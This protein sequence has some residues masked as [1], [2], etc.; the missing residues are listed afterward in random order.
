MTSRRCCNDAR[1]DVKLV[2][3]G[4]DIGQQQQQSQAKHAQIGMGL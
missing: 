2:D 3:F 1:C 4:V